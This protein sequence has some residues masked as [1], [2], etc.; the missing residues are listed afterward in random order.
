MGFPRQEYWSGVPLPCPL[1]KTSL[2]HAHCTVITDWLYLWLSAYNMTF[3]LF[4]FLPQNLTQVL[5][6]NIC[7]KIWGWPNEWGHDNNFHA[8]NLKPWCAV[9]LSYSQEFFLAQELKIEDKTKNWKRSI[10]IPIPKKV[11][12]KE[13]SN[14]CTIAKQQLEL[15]MKQQTGSKLGKEDVRVIYCHPAYLTYMQG[16]SWEMLA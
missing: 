8:V 2:W 5:A 16:T 7:Q 9:S 12:A 14:Y 15:D 4:L 13:R 3:T 6:C 11:N 10:F 1:Y